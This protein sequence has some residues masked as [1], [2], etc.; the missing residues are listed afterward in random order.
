MRLEELKG[1]S[2]QNSKRSCSAIIVVGLLASTA[3]A[4]AQ[5]V[6]RGTGVADRSR[7]QYD[8]IGFDLGTFRV[9]PSISAQFDVTD[10][11]RAR[12]TDRQ[13][14][15][16][17]A[18]LPEVAFASNWGRH[19]L[20]GRAY[21]NRS[22]HAKLPSEDAT[23]YGASVNGALDVSRDTVLRAD[24]SL[25]RTV[26]SRADLGSFRNSIEPVRVDTYHA[27][28]GVAQQF[29]RLKL[30]GSV[31]VNK[32]TFGDV[33]GLDGTVI[34]QNFRDVRTISESLSGQ[35]DVGGG[36]GLIVSGSANQNRFSFRPGSTGF[37]PLLNL[38]RDSSGF[39]LQGGVVLE[40][41]SLVFG[42]I[43]AGYIRQSYSDPRLQDF[44]G[45]SFSADVLWN[46][47]SLTSLRFRASRTVQDTSSTTV[48]GNTRSDFSVRI[49]HELYRYVILT[50]TANYGS[51]QPNGPGIGGREYGIRLGG[52]YLI[53]RHWSAGLTGGYAR[54][55]S[56]STFLRYKAVF[57]SLSVRYAF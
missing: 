28:V 38:N 6:E 20:G 5:S 36:I 48:A 9:Y 35:Y 43:Q 2:V 11:Y 8:P 10:N 27:A 55:D 42:T 13:G 18:I 50:G 56:A 29:N 19:R 21:F 3:T 54:R 32:I 53:D 40:L 25:T 1:W 12:D 31:G 14:D 57:G 39:S 49:D 52:R 33:I 46:V 30:D 26:E 24:A 16:Y 44:A 37:N 17:A 45:L 15:I 23:Q 41:S 4:R 7:P 47:T 34:D 51:F 22:V